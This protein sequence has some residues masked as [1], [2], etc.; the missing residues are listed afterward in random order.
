MM[1]EKTTVG[2]ARKGGKELNRTCGDQTERGRKMRRRGKA[3]YRLHLVSRG[4]RVPTL[5]KYLFC[6]IHRDETRR[7]CGRG[8]QIV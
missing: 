4:E 8:S 3:G 1:I 7:L 2:R 6:R 5:F